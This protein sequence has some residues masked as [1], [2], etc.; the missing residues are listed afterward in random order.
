MIENNLDY[1]QYYIYKHLI[2]TKELK[3]Y[4]LNKAFEAHVNFNTPGNSSFS[5][6][7]LKFLS[8]EQI[9][10]IRGNREFSDIYPEVF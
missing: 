2:P 1:P 5:R 3:K 9:E 4:Y 8:P 6:E 7:L 10:K